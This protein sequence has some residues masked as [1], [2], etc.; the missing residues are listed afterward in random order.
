MLEVFGDREIMIG[1]E[2]TKKFEEKIRGKISEII[3][4][5]EKRSLKGEM[6][7]VVPG[8]ENK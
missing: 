4:L 6:V 7:V 1:R 8:A 5:L 3:P 2:M